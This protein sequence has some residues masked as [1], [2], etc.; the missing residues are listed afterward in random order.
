[1]PT[2]LIP[3]PLGAFGL[4]GST[5]ASAGFSGPL[6]QELQTR[7]TALDPASAGSTVGPFRTIAAGMVVTPTFASSSQYPAALCINAASHNNQYPLGIA[8]ENISAYWGA[9]GS[10]GAQKVQQAQNQMGSIA[11]YGLVY[12]MFC[13]TAHPGA[14]DVGLP[15][16]A[17]IATTSQSLFNAS[18]HY[19]LLALSTANIVSSTIAASGIGPSTLLTAFTAANVVGICYTSQGGFSVTASNTSGPQMY[20]VMLTGPNIS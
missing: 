12:G 16:Y 10:T 14:G 18:C 20:P 8:V 1:M 4:P 2:P 17:V 11:T 5:G 15:A 6:T 13:S 9:T 3:N 19:G 7:S